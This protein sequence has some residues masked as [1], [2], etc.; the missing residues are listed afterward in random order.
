M[1]KS[2]VFSAAVLL[3]AFG[4]AAAGKTKY[5]VFKPDG[6]GKYE[7]LKS[8]GKKYKYFMLEQGQVID[9]KIIGPT[10]VKIR[11]RPAL[12]GKIKSADFEIQVWE[13]DKLIAGRKVN[14]RKSKLRTDTKGIDI[15][16]FIRKR[17]RRNRNM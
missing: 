2:L 1:R 9:F 16:G 17:K 11:V 3:L 4:T 8:D 6:A 15:G 7:F 10:K 14:S 12:E 13:G 5:R